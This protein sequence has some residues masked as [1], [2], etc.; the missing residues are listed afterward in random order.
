[1]VLLQGQALPWTAV[2]RV[3]ADGDRF[4][5]MIYE[6]DA[7]LVRSSQIRQ[8]DSYLRNPDF[9]PHRIREVS[10]PAASFCSWVLGMVQMRLWKTGK[11][12]EATDPLLEAAGEAETFA[13]KLEKKRQEQQEM[14]KQE[15]DESTLGL[16]GASVGMD[17]KSSTWSDVRKGLDAKSPGRRRR[18]T[19]GDAADEGADGK[20]LLAAQ[21]NL[22]TDSWQ[23]GR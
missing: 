5:H 10:K 14:L 7:D 2:R 16:F 17:Y 18:R 4:M 12:N 13:Q 23:A 19:K 20:C 11:G 15:Q 1:M 6:F 9:R 3:M 21:S 8:L 22:P